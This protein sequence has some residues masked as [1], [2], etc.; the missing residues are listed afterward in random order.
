[1]TE[2]T[3]IV[4]ISHTIEY[5]DQHNGRPLTDRD[6][7]RGER[8]SCI[9]AYRSPSMNKEP[10]FPAYLHTSLREELWRRMP[11]CEYQEELADELRD[12]AHELEREYREYLP[13]P[14]DGLRSARRH[15]GAE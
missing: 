11:E 4:W 15:G 5:S 7:K 14:G 2:R 3:R 12:F 9:T 13:L 1:M 8:N 10:L 6:L